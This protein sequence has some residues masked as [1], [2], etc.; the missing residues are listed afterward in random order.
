MIGLGSGPRAACAALLAVVAL[1]ACTT[2]VGGAPVAGTTLPDEPAELT[3]EVVFDD[4]TTI[5]PCSLTDPDVFDTYGDVEFGT[6][7]SLDYCAISVDTPDGANAVISVG[8]F[9]ELSALPDLDGKRVKD[10]DGGLWVG[11]QDDDPSFCAQLLVFP[12]GV[13]MQVAGSVYEGE[14]DTCP[15]VEAGMDK[16]I[17]VIQDEGVEH[18]DPEKD[19][20]LSIDPCDLIEDDDVAAIAGLAGVERPNDYPGKHTCFWE[21]PAAD[22]RV[23]VRLTFG[24][25]LEPQAYGDGANTNPVAGR[26]SATN[27]Y[28]TVGDGSY[29]TVETA[30][31]PFTEVE[32]HDDAFELASVFVRMP[33]GQ[34]TAGCAAA[35]AVANIVWPELPSV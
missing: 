10:V 28:P 9:G 11:Q 1:S 4:L 14:T 33:A 32:G 15:M 21:V 2:R 26:P 13:T 24:A 34:V 12:D 19:S 31:L 29:C 7:E 18:R 35:L 8:S 16:A 23:S 5:E 17:S 25:G 30:H 22:T 20:L 27:P 6:P 3:S